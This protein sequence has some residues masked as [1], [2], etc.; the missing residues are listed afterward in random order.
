MNSHSKEEN[1]SEEIVTLLK[2]TMVKYDLQDYEG[3]GNDIAK[4]A[5]QLCKDKFI[6]N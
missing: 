5:M 4:I 3:I 1:V 2:D 6:L